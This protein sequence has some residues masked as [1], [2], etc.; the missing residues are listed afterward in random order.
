MGL[1]GVVVVGLLH[2][3]SSTS[4]LYSVSRGLGPTFYY[5]PIHFHNTKYIALLSYCT[6]GR[7]SSE[8]VG[9]WA[10]VEGDWGEIW[11]GYPSQSPGV[12]TPGKFLKIWV[13]ICAIWCI[14]GAF[15]PSFSPSYGR[16]GEAAPPNPPLVVKISEGTI[17]YGVG[18]RPMCLVNN[19]NQSWSLLCR[20]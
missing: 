13:Q 1:L 5:W 14:L 17:L 12:L 15:G 18:C 19:L 2:F 10:L 3:Y 20:K 8:K 11:G 7:E 16:W 6:S 4:Q 9:R